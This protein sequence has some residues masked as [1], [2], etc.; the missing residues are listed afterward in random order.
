[1]QDPIKYPN[2]LGQDASTEIVFNRHFN[3]GADYSDE[4]AAVLNDAAFETARATISA[5]PGYATTPLLGLPGIA[6]EAGVAA[7]HYKDEGGRFGLGSFKAL[8]GAYAV[9]RLLTREVAARKGVDAPQIEEILAGVHDDVIS[10]ITVCCA[11]DGNHGRSVAWGARTFGCKCVI[12]IHATVSDG[13][14]SAIEAYGAEV[15]RCAGNYDDS[16]R[17]ADETAR[18]EGWFVVSDTSYPGY[19]EIPKDVMQ[20]YEVMAAEAAEQL[21]AAPTHVFVQTGVG[22]VAAAVAAQLRRRYGG[23]QVPRVILADPEDSACWLETIRNGEPTAV[24]GD[25]DTLMAGLACGEISLL[26]WDVLKPLC[27][28]TIS[29][30]DADAV[31]SMRRLAQ[32]V[33]GDPAVVAGESAVAG[34]AAF[35]AAAGNAEA[36]AA[37]GLD[38]AS[39]VLVFGTEADTD[40]ALYEEL[41]GKSAD[42]VRAGA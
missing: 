7:L 36:R 30:A 15:R 20:G 4:Q 42:A 41:V 16:V 31:A 29:V 5:W 10:A 23:A 3:Q 21:D 13:R 39:R 27:F 34:L 2:T 17:E 28:A 35:L 19:T 18:A 26:A 32:P 25:L 6:A 24:T 33:A 14:K 40:P 9:L 12:F 1:M 38:A 11:T 22:G 8:G 37:L